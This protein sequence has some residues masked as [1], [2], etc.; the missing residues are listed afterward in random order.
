MIA[1]S[2]LELI[3]EPT[4]EPVSLVELKNHLRLPL[5]EIEDETIEDNLLTNQIKAARE[6]V[7]DITRRGIITQTWDY[8][9]DDW[10]SEDYIVL[11]LGNLQSVTY[12]NWKGT[13]DTLTTLTE[14]TDY[15]VE[16]NGEQCG[17]VVLP[18]NVSWPTGTLH[19]SKPVIIRFICGWTSADSV[20]AK[21]RAAI[22][23]IAGD[24][25]EHRE[26]QTLSSMSFAENETVMRLLSSA[27][28]WEEV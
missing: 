14:D 28:L 19:P 11:P 4:V 10:P 25:Y 3:T 16:T 18:Y 7:E 1:K 15:V 23:M 17:R 8:F 2:F 27:R 13:D 24:L 26:R 21:I 20:P 5:E 12:V 22:K 6:E 9:L